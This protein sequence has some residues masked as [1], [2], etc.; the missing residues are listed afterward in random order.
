MHGRNANLV[1]SFQTIS[2]YFV[3]LISTNIQLR[4][5][6]QLVKSN[7]NRE[8][9]GK[10]FCRN[11]INRIS[12]KWRFFRYAYEYSRVS[13][14][15][16]KAYL[17]MGYCIVPYL[18][19][20]VPLEG[21]YTCKKINGGNLIYIRIYRICTCTGIIKYSYFWIIIFQI[22]KYWNKFEYHLNNIYIYYL[23][24]N[25]FQFQIISL[26]SLI[27]NIIMNSSFNTLYEEDIFSNI[28]F[29]FL[30]SNLWKF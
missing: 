10:N 13:N 23:L 8:G 7:F 27:L 2:L 16:W 6:M 21:T 18:N 12:A 30:L 24:D 22:G 4:F 26:Y 1:S 25:N 9:G 5:P 29:C 15:S 3:Q 19:S 17:N 20:I 11:E 28:S 14:T